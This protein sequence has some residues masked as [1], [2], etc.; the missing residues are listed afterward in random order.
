MNELTAR[1]MI[2]WG[3]MSES[4]YLE[5]MHPEPEYTYEELEAENWLPDELGF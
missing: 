5:R 1:L 3:I 2:E 4:E